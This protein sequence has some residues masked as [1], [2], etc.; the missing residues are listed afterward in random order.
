[1]RQ[2]TLDCLTDPYNHKENPCKQRCDCECHDKQERK[3]RAIRRMWAN[4]PVKLSKQIGVCACILLIFVIVWLIDT[5][6]LIPLKKGLMFTQQAPF[7]AFQ[8]VSP[9]GE[10]EIWGFY[11]MMMENKLLQEALT[12]DQALGAILYLEERANIKNDTGLVRKIYHLA[13]MWHYYGIRSGDKEALKKAKIYYEKGLEA[14]P[15][16]TQFLIGLEDLKNR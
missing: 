7:S 11:A 5:G 13:L 10:D 1:M 3:Y 15:N 6:A 12:Q 8:V 14:S 16:R 2:K 4:I 9:I